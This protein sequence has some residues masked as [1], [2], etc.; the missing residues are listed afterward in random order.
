MLR[1]F[2]DQLEDARARGA[3]LRF[4]VR[5]LVDWVRSMPSV[6]VAEFRR[7]LAEEPLMTWH[8]LL[9]RGLTIA[10]N[11]AAAVWITAG[12]LVWCGIRRIIGRSERV[13]G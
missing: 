2:E 1:L 4:Y 10:P 11:L 5:T 6:H 9:E 7:R 12:V 8:R 13:A 3:T